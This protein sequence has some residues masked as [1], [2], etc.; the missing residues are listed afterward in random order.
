MAQP[1]TSRI[2][3]RRSAALQEGGADYTAKRADLIRVAAE[4]FRDKGYA[5]ATLNDIAAVFGTDRASLYYYVGSKEELFQ[6]C[7]TDSVRTNIA[8][9][10][11]IARTS[12]SPR[13]KLERLIA[14][15]IHS[16]VEHYPYMYVYIQED[17]RQVAT[18]EAD[19][20]QDMV[21]Q[22]HAMERLF[23]DVIAE[24]VADGS[25]RAD[26]SN[27]LIANSLFGMTQWTH[28]WF[29]PGKS[30]YN[31]QDLTRVFSAILFQGINSN[32]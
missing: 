23:L 12:I 10:Q 21:E 17:M 26:L 5:A 14:L 30:K 9:A 4:V 2:A 8:L 29:V 11:D 15:I 18:Q 25:F 19:W 3:Q 31:E 20:A 22:T 24:G 28:R 13:E 32:S 27:T 16:Q 1:V 7:I 6:E